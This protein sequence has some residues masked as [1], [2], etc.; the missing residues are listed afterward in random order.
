MIGLGSDK[1]MGKRSSMSHC[2]HMFV[3]IIFPVT[4]VAVRIAGDNAICCKN[5]SRPIFYTSPVKFLIPGHCHLVKSTTRLN[6]KTGQ[7]FLPRP[8]SEGL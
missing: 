6:L 4:F 1:K 2:V 8:P 7:L 5:R 3:E